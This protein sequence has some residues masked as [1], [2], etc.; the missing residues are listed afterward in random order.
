MTGLRRH[1]PEIAVEWALDEPGRLWQAVDGTLCFADI[2]GFTA[3]SEKLSRRGRIGGEELVETLSRVFGGMLDAARERDGMLLKF[4]G[5][6]LLFL[7]KGPDHAVRAA[8][9]AV[10]M[11]QALR[12]AKEI[13]T[14]VGPL[15]LSMSVGLHSGQI[16]LFLVGS[17]HRELVLA[18]PD[19]SLAAATES[20]ANAGEIGISP[21]TAALLPPSAVRP[22]EDGLL[23][24]RWRRPPRPPAGAS[25]CAAAKSTPRPLE[26]S[27]VS[28]RAPHLTGKP[29]VSIRS[30][31]PRIAK[32]SLAVDSRDS[33]IWKRGN[34]SLSSSTTR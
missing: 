14:S 33:P 23:L 25:P 29:A 4:G 34:R 1:I 5:D 3:L 21:S 31:M 20:A 30:A 7:F 13:P 19:A 32:A 11:R 17:K 24:L 28:R 9:T 16:H 26:P 15:N 10:E 12:K 27:W 8:S 6:A 22:R 18:G 2:S